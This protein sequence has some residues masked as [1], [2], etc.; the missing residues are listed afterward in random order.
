MDLKAIFKCFDHK[1]L[2]V[3][4]QPH[5]KMSMIMLVKAK[6]RLNVNFLSPKQF[7]FELATRT[8]N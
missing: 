2:A 3:K 1:F 5:I 8:D 6:H 4:D 7:T